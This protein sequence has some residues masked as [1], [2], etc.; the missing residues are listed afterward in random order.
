MKG[1]LLAF[2]LLLPRKEFSEFLRLIFSEIVRDQHLYLAA[3]N[4]PGQPAKKF[5]RR[6]VPKGY[7]PEIIQADDGI[8]GGIEDCLKLGFKF[9]NFFFR[10]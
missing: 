2:F 9:F 5:F 8:A 7:A 6:R 10:G 3:L 4:L 1:D